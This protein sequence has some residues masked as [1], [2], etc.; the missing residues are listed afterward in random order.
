MAS[1]NDNYWISFADI[2]T[3]LMVIFLL[4]AVSYM[5]LMEKKYG[6]A[7]KTVEDI[8]KTRETI[9]QELDSVFADDLNRWNAEIS[10]DLSV[11]FKNPTILF[12]I[13]SEQITPYFH[14]VLAE[15]I[16]KYLDVLLQEKYNG[17]LSEIRVEG[18]T[19]DYPITANGDP[20]VDNLVLSQSRAKNIVA[21]IRSR[22]YYIS[23]PNDKKNNLQHLL[24]ANGMSYG[25]ALDSD[26]NL[27]YKSGKTID[28]NKS[29]RV[30][31]KAVVSTE[32]ILKEKDLEIKKN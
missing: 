8:N 15:F 16:P 17:K 25:K 12:D 29:R 26:Y 23:L 20:Y 24:T 13:G 2:M 21:F 28:H 4:I 30:E 1:K 19:D 6:Q 27:V 3:G 32:D 9:K 18:H 22:Q 7:G 11:K 14:G 10:D 31:F 5:A